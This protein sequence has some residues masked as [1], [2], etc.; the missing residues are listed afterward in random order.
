MA[1]KN[2]WSFEPGETIV[3]EELMKQC[4]DYD[5]Y[6]P[7]KDT[8]IDILG[9]HKITKK[10]LQFQVKESR[11]YEKGPHSWHQ[12][13]V[14]NFEENSHR[15]DYYI[16][17]TYIPTHLFPKQEKV[18]FKTEFIIVPMK[19]LLRR[20]Q[21]KTPNKADKHNF[22][23]RYYFETGKVL[24]IRQKGKVWDKD[25]DFEYTQFKNN[26]NLIK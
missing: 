18:S 23:F 12:E 26:W 6:F 17:V 2:Y 7:L 13:S 5:F 11:Y 4:P 1:V 25:K 20:V 10:V 19:E 3:A 16:F 24:E 9:V 14:K 15:C 22:Y 8:G 21:K